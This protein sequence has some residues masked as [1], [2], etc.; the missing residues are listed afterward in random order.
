VANSLP[1]V[2]YDLALGG[3][4]SSVFVPVVVEARRDPDGRR[5]IGALVGTILA[6]LFGVSVMASVLAPFLVKLFTFRGGATGGEQA[7]LAAFLFRFFSFQILF[8]GIAAV[9]GG[10][11]NARN[12]FAVPA[13]APAANNVVSIVVFLLFAAFM[14]RRDVTTISGSGKLLLGIGTTGAVAAM[15]IV[16]WAP[17]R[18]LVGT[19]PLRVSF[20]NR[21]VRRFSRLS[22]WIVVY[23]AT[24]QLEGVVTYVF[25]YGVQGG[26]TAYITALS[27][28][29]LPYAVLAASVMT[30]LLPR[31]AAH[32]ADGDFDG[33][34]ERLEHGIVMTITMIV[35]AGVAYAVVA[36][37][38]MHVLLVRGQ[39][40]PQS[41]ALVARLLQIF[42]VGLPGYS[43]WLLFLRAFYSLQD[44]RT[45]ALVNFAAGVGFV[46]LDFVFYPFLKVEG[47]GWVHALG[48][49]AAAVH[50][51]RALDR[52][53]GGLDW[54]SITVV[55][56]K[57][58]AAAAVMGG[59]MAGIV[60]ALNDNLTGTVGQATVVVAALGVGA[61]TFLTSAAL[62]DV[63]Q[64]SELRR[65]LL[66]RSA[67]D[68]PAR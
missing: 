34:C 1:N 41:A 56:V 24:S 66:R 68:G 21:L 51:G 49:T 8:Y 12:H 36:G 5:D 42:T 57:V 32:A 27:F 52:R 22:A 47:L 16:S 38:A 28:F 59:V 43:L 10:L 25:A 61:V 30:V 19:L 55:A 45:P 46:A 35:P 29:Q 48:Y 15:A 58:S 60:V 64:V 63:G 3:M 17:L 65:L 54:P 13:F 31:L 6:V 40:T 11:L 23:V 20:S 2:L 62:L 4:L 26:A 18:R 44:A 53:L 14:G 67:G 33:F 39:V 7:A 50:A 37:P 9:A